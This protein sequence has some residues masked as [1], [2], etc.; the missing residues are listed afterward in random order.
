MTRKRS[1]ALEAWGVE[2]QTK[3]KDKKDGQNQHESCCSQTTKTA[4]VQEEDSKVS[5]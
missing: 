3:T 2:L 5:E 4:T 1:V